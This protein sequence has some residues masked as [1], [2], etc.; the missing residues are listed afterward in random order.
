MVEKGDN[1]Q[2]NIINEMEMKI[3]G[4]KKLRTEKCKKSEKNQNIINNSYESSLNSSV[5]TKNFENKDNSNKVNNNF[6]I[7][8]S[9]I[10]DKNLYIEEYLEELYF[11]L[12]EEEKG[13]IKKPIYGYMSLQNNI[14]SKMRALLIDWLIGVHFVLNLKEETLYQTIWIIDTYL[15]FEIIE[16]KN[17]QLLGI[18]SLFIACKNNEIVIPDNN[19][20]VIL[21]DGAYEMEELLSMEKKILYKIDFNILAPT[22]LH[23]YNI[24]SKVFNFDKTKYNLGKYIMETS[25][26]EDN[27]LYFPPSIIALT[28][29]YMVI[30]FFG[31]KESLFLLFINNCKNIYNSSQKNIIKELAEQLR[32]WIKDLNKT[33]LL[34]IKQKY[35][36]DKFDRVALF[37]EMFN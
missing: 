25:L 23:F 10:H 32:F 27:F 33:N 7:I 20:F 18:T 28:C 17:F 30:K 4:E 6:D 13:L 36:S 3:D 21:T 35:S 29:I 24:L 12:L 19:N 26:L 1:Y 31:I 9:N 2:R 14:N 16:R 37:H 5:S 11:N 8:F 15:S 22:T 34:S